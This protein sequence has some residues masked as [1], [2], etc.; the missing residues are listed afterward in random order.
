MTCPTNLP[1]LHLEG[2]GL[3]TCRDLGNHHVLHQSAKPM[4]NHGTQGNQ[5][6]GNRSVGGSVP[7]VAVIS[8]EF[9]WSSESPNSLFPCLFPCIPCFPWFPLWILLLD[10][11]LTPASARH[12]IG[13]RDR[14][15]IVDH[16][17]LEALPRWGETSPWRTDWQTEPCLKRR[18]ESHRT[19]QLPMILWFIFL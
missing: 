8:N 18:P 2:P 6:R 13:W 14:G 11:R 15:E 3:P 5:L 17:L 1:P 4:G 12:S 9:P 10:H 16:P 7:E 19:G